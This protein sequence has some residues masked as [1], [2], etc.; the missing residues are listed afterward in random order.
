MV[1][2]W[3]MKGKLKIVTGILALRRSDCG[4]NWWVLSLL[5]LLR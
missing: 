1:V 4:V 2:K 3:E 5:L